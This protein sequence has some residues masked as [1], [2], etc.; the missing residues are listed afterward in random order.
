MTSEVARVYTVSAAILVFFVGW[1]GIAARPWVSAPN[2]TLTALARREQRLRRDAALVTLV[3][4]S[5]AEARR[6]AGLAAQPPARL[7]PAPTAR[8]VQLPPVTE[9][10]SS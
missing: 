9:T 5:R 2:P 3:A 7:A 4:R 8:F 1:A 6:T 10:R